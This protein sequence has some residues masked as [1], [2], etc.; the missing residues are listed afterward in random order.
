MWDHDGAGT[1]L[2]HGKAIIS[3][4]L[5]QLRPLGE[6]LEHPHVA[7]LSPE[8]A[9]EPPGME[10]IRVLSAA[11]A[12]HL[13]I[14]SLMVIHLFS[15]QLRLVV[16]VAPE[17]T[18]LPLLA[19]G[20]PL[21]PPQA[22]LQPLSRAPWTGP[23]INNEDLA[24]SFPVS[25]PFLGSPKLLALVLTLPPP[26]PPFPAS[27]ASS[28][29]LTFPEAALI[30]AL[31]GAFGNPLATSTGLQVGTRNENLAFSA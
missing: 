7:Q 15:S 18:Q 5:K 29:G 8:L 2:Q 3:D 19:S 30:L 24:L 25:L 13:I 1:S 31:W 4:P 14:F 9:P 11:P 27:A 28:L 22:T 23:V 12:L 21:A 26:P 10:I 20:L 17:P 6:V 16:V